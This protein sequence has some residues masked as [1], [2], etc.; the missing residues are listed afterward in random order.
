MIEPKIQR[1]EIPPD[2]RDEALYNLQAYWQTPC[3]E[4]VVDRR[5]YNKLQKSIRL[6]Y[7]ERLI[8]PPG[9]TIDMVQ[10]W[11]EFSQRVLVMHRQGM[12]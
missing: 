4:D 10:E 7:Y 6:G 11:C 3:F 8:W 5:M 1:I 9:T 12:V 2:K